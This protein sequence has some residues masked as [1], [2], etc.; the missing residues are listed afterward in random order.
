MPTAKKVQDALINALPEHLEGAIVELGSGW[1]QLAYALSKKYP[2]CQVT[3]YET[4]HIPYFVSRLY[5]HKTLS[6][7]RKDL[8]TVPL[9]EAKLVVCYLY[10]GAMK[11]LENKLEGV[12]GLLVVSHT[13]SLPGYTPT[14]TIAVDDLYGTK[15]YFYSIGS[16]A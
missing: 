14:K 8:F 6:F 12:N 1:G 7:K 4:S 5:S 11:R 3:G 10:P 9:D 2:N 16:S 15:I 13:F